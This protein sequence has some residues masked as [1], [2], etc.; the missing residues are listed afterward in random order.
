MLHFPALTNP[1][2]KNQI[3]SKICGHT[4]SYDIGRCKMMTFRGQMDDKSQKT[5]Y[6]HY[7]A[8]A[9]LMYDSNSIFTTF[10][11][12]ESIKCRHRNYSNN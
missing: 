5:Q 1:G 9:A 7:Q 11:E 10:S 12:S 4:F 3:K 2:L 6:N 8:T